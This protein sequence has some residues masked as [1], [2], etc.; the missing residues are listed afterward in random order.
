MHRGCFVW[1]PTPPLAGRR[2]PHPGPVRVCVC[3]SVLNRSG[4]PASRARFRAP[5]LSFGHFV[6]LLCS[7]PSGLGLPLACSFVC[8]LSSC[9]VPFARPCCRLLSL[10]SGPGCLGPSRFVFFSSLPVVWFFFLFLCAPLVSG[11]LWSPAP[12]ALGL[13]AVCCLF[14]WSPASRLCVRSRCF[15]VFRLAVGCSLVV[16][17]PSPPFVSRGFRRCL[18]VLPFFFCA[19]PLSQAFSGFWPRVPWALALCVVCFVGLPLLGSSCALAAFVVSAWQLAAP[20]WLLPPPQPLLCLAVFVAAARCSV[21]FSALGRVGLECRNQGGLVVW[22]LGVLS[23]RL[24]GPG[25][26]RALPVGRA[27]AA[28]SVGSAG[29]CVAASRVDC[30]PGAALVVREWLCAVWA[31]LLHGG[32]GAFGSR[33]VWARGRSPVGGGCR[34]LTLGGSSLVSLW[35]V[36]WWPLV[37]WLWEVPVACRFHGGTIVCCRVC[38][39]GAAGCGGVACGGAARGEIKG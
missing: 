3:S 35:C 15:C 16:A 32:E 1:A 39:G 20:W 19:P 36:P 26:R 28:T 30:G 27:R 31:Y 22:C 2:T 10:V 6:V 37:G 24:V 23:H 14:C 5:H 9:V 29:R 4:G 34:G 8:L 33:L 12:G 17:A 18:S 25:A 7:A 13:G 21:F 11:F 38:V